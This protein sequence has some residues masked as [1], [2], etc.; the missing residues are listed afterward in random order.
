MVPHA[1]GEKGNFG[2]L[3]NKCG[4]A[5]AVR[6]CNDQVAKGSW[7]AS[8]ACT[9]S[10]NWGGTTDIAAHAM[11]SDHVGGQVYWF[12]CRKPSEVSEARFVPGKGITA[13]C[14]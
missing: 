3:E 9:G 2:K 6:F 5:I 11:S 12:A 10:A 14:R 8:M 1:A 7:E 4:F 13:H